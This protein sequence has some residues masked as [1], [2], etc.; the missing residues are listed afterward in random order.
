M[1]GLT[2]IAVATIVLGILHPPRRSGEYLV[3]VG[4]YSII[5]WFV[6]R[7][8]RRSWIEA[9]QDTVRVADL[10][11]GM[12]T[13]PRSEVASIE[14]HSWKWHLLKV[15]GEKVFIRPVWTKPQFDQLASFLGVAVHHQPRD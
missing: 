9:D 2:A 7:E 5:V 1:W 15:S 13:V 4:C 14:A 11:W 10:H 6:L 8:T 12:R 3:W